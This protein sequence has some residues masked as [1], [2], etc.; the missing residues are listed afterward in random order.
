MKHGRLKAIVVTII[1]LLLGLGITSLLV[2]PLELP[3]YMMAVGV[4]FLESESPTPPIRKADP[5]P[6]SPTG[7][8]AASTYPIDWILLHFAA[9][10]VIL[11]FWR[12]PI[13]GRPSPPEPPGASDF[14]KHID[15][16]AGL[17]HRS[18]DRTYAMSRLRDYHKRVKGE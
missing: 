8:E 17:L 4:V 18:R 5:R 6:R 3:T 10:G 2:I 14:G 16:V 13:F 11:C 9:V 1:G 7:L 12:W 15:A